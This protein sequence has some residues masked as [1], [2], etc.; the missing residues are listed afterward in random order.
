MEII[1][2][3]LKQM[4][5]KNIIYVMDFPDRETDKIVYL[6]N[7]FTIKSFRPKYP[8][9]SHHRYFWLNCANPWRKIE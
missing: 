4:A 8:I 5:D 7:L 3:Y 1:D 9:I 2:P 6:D